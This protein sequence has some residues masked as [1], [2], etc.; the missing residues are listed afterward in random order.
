[1]DDLPADWIAD[2]VA[3]RQ[4]LHGHPELLFDLTRTAGVVA[5]SLRDRGCDEVVEGIGRSGVVA[6]IKGKNTGPTIGLRADMDALPISE[7]TQLSYASQSLGKMHACGHDGHIAMLLLAARKLAQSRDFLGTAVLVF[8]PAEENGGAGARAMLQDGLIERFGLERIFGL[9]IMPG[10]P[11]GQF[12]TRSTGI[13]AAADSLRITVAGKGGHAGRP[14]TCI[15]PLLVC[16]HIHVALQSILSR[17]L[18][19]VKAGVVSVTM[20][21]ASDNE[22]TIA[23]KAIMR[24]TVRTLGED[25]RDL[26]EARLRAMVPAIAQGFGA[27]AEVVYLRDYPVTWN[28]PKTTELFAN[29]AAK[30]TTTDTDTSP[31]MIS[32]DFGFFGAVVP[33]SF[34]FLG[35]GDGPSLHDPSFDFDDNLLPLGARIWLSVMSCET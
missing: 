25:A 10:L 4:D 28:D 34:G 24:G 32:E 8:Q 19:P 5:R 31:R 21:E 3:L 30:V 2:T 16:S 9:H 17:N 12:A 29:A 7:M 35:M 18:D 11:K 27:D 13:M 6:V 26:I 15:D 20:M 14:E 22:D 23:S 33:A 1:M